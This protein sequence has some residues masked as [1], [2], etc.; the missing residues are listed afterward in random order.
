MQA[1]ASVDHQNRRSLLEAK[2]RRSAEVK[3]T[4]TDLQRRG[5]IRQLKDRHGGR[6]FEDPAHDQLHAAYNHISKSLPALEAEMQ[7]AEDRPLQFLQVCAAASTAVVPLA[8]AACLPTSDVLQWLRVPSG[9]PQVCSSVG[10][11][12]SMPCT[13]PRPLRRSTMLALPVTS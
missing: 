4:W 2:R 1:L 12:C 13:S 5:A 7:E 3:A 11:R 9:L 8:S 10:V 6:F